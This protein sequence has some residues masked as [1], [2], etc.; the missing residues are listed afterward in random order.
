MADET[1][2][3]TDSRNLATPEFALLTTTT[4]EFDQDRAEAEALHSE[5]GDRAA[6]AQILEN[7]SRWF[8]S[9]EVTE[10]E[11]MLARQGIHLEAAEAQRT[12]RARQAEEMDRLIVRVLSEP[13]AI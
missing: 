8:T 4:P 6:S 5:L 1:E 11:Q 10:E 2:R 7:T 3:E 12:A 13:E 9:P